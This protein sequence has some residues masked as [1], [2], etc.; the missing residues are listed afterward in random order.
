MLVILTPV[1]SFTNILQA[2]FALVFICQRITKLNCNKRK[3]A[4]STLK[5]AYLKMLLRLTPVVSFTNILY[6]AFF[7]IPFFQKTKNKETVI[8]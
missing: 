2:A 6:A 4:Q 5:K 3:A 7:P 1:I 8:T